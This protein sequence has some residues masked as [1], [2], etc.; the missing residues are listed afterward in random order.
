MTPTSL[1]PRLD[2]ARIRHVLLDMDGT[3][4]DLAF[5]NFFWRQ[6]VPSRYAEARGLSLEQAQAELTPQFMAVAHTLPWYDTDYWSHVTGLDLCA[7]HWEFKHRASLLDG[8]VEFLDAVRA[9]GRTLWIATNA[10]PDSW[11]PKMAQTGIAHYFAHIV[12]SNDLQAPKEDPRFWQRLQAQHPF[13]PAQALFCDDSR[14]VLEAARDFGIGQIVAMTHPDT[15][16]PGREF[17]DFL[18]VPRLNRLLPLA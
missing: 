1:T 18:S 12:S 13:D 14:P 3:M 5:D 6:L 7:L 9:S 17:P 10:H 2:W 15:T 16:Q 8:T 11:K 4:L